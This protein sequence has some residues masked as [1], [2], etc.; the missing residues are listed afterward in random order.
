MNRIAL[1]AL[2]L[3]AGCGGPP[4]PSAPSPLL[5]KPMPDVHRRALDGA[6]VD[7]ARARGQVVIVDFFAKYCEPCRRTLPELE[8]LHRDEPSVLVVGVDEDENESDAREVVDS[9]RLTFEVVHD[10]DHVLS[11]RYRVTDLP[12]TFVAG[13]EGAIRWAGGEHLTSGDLAR[14]VATAR[15]PPEPPP[16]QGPR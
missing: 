2:L 9:L 13:P 10:R 1:S 11:G 8:A 15:R 7:T 16:G 3:L 14:A 6:L 4:S 5:A 12:M